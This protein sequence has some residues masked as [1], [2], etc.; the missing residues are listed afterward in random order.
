MQRLLS[1]RNVV[2]SLAKHS[3]DLLRS[4]DDNVIVVHGVAK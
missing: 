4:Q 1:T 2:S 3:L